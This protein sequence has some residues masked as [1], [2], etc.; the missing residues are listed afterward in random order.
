MRKE[1]ER[2]NKGL[3]TGVAQFPPVCVVVPMGHSSTAGSRD[4]CWAHT[5]QETSGNV[6]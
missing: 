5:K 6:A 2:R 4:H 3:R 1:M